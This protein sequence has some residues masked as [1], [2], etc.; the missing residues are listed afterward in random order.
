MH[1]PIPPNR[2]KQITNDACDSALAT[3][4]AYDHAATKTWNDQIINSILRALISESGSAGDAASKYKFAVN[5]TII[6]HLSDTRPEGT[7]AGTQT[8]GS[9]AGIGEDGV[10]R[11]DDSMKKVGRRGMHSA[12]GAYWNN[13]RDGMWS[14]KYEGGEGK[15]LDIVVSVLWIAV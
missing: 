9:A 12:S 14:H 8:D 2:L 3:A 11:G 10:S 13:E 6:Q 4:S 1:Q 7:E 15:G 5:S